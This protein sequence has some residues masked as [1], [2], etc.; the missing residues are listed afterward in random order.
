M[1]IKLVTDLITE[2]MAKNYI[3]EISFS[4]EDENAL[5]MGGSACFVHKTANEFGI[6]L[7]VARSNHVVV[8][9]GEKDKVLD[10]KKK[11]NQF[12]NGGDGY[13]VSKMVVSE[14]AV[15]SVI[16]KG[17]SR[18]MELEGKH[19]GVKVFIER[20]N[21]VITLRG[22]DQP[23]QDC[24][25]E[26][27]KIVSSVRVQES[28][29]LSPQQHAELSKTDVVRK[30]TSGIPVQVTVT[31][32]EVAV[33]GIFTDVR[34]SLSLLKAHLTGVYETHVELDASQYSKVSAAC[35]DPSH[36]DRMKENTSTEVELDPSSS[37]IVIRG[38]RGGVKKA[39]FLVMDYLAFLLPS[40]FQHIK[41]PK[42][43]QSTVASAAS[44]A[45]TAAVSGASVV[46]DRDLNSILVQSSD[47]DKAKEAV[48]LIKAKMV[49]AEK[50]VYL[51]SIEQHEPWLIPA[52]IGKSGQK[53]RGME[54]ETGCR[55]DVS[56]QE[57]TITITGTDEESVTKAK[58]AL[59]AAIDKARREC[60]FIR[61]P[62]NAVPAFIGKS[63][64]HIRQFADEHGVEVERVRKDPSMV[65][66]G[67]QE[68]SVSAAKAA[69][70][71]WIKV[72]EEN[73]AEASIPVEKFMFGAVLGK[74]GSKI[75]AIQ[76]D[77][78]CRIDIDRSSSLVIV[79]GS[80]TEKRGE[81]IQKIKDIIAEEQAI[82]SEREQKKEK[83]AEER[84]Q[85]SKTEK[86]QTT[87]APTDVQPSDD[88][89]AR[90]DRTTEFSASP[91]GLTTRGN[92]ASKTSRKQ[93]S[94]EAPLVGTAAG[95]SLFNLL[96]SD[97]SL[98][99]EEREATVRPGS[100]PTSVQHASSSDSLS[101][102]DEAAEGPVYVKSAS[103]FAVRV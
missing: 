7:S 87:A 41:M 26:I 3:E 61:L 51:H 23:V 77:T 59:F 1:Q 19:E 27:L 15:G 103:G 48:A 89:D 76:K 64:A 92:K 12:L 9:R 30:L 85:R 6:E 71:E 75:N 38:K 10:A 4:P 102:G 68:D 98:D 56:K 50:L 83:E 36:F 54:K 66:I 74:D 16:G 73:N 44:L 100:L 24:R 62:S 63:G 20:T 95:R 69:L 21:G 58:A 70:L 97:S 65:R 31:E 99:T 11:V 93:V 80:T 46:L 45:D 84:A 90:K 17:G 25:T 101:N 5:L 67:G 42:A 49:E 22:P 94:D 13:S 39:K 72:W 43:F 57:L 8:A 32:T 2:F 79:R 78:G 18:R 47:P 37:S 33:R 82:A 96:V 60:V 91:V 53:I 14:Q 34:D 35:R 88:L 55:I 29:P 86:K 28:M 81:A 52:I 40:N